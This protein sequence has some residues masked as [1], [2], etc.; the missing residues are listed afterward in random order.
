[1]WFYVA[2]L[3]LGVLIYFKF[4]HNTLPKPNYLG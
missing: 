2:V 3:A 4:I 1:M